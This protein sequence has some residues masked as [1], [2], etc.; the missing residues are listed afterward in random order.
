M[1]NPLILDFEMYVF[2]SDFEHCIIVVLKGIK[3]Y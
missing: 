3:G 1:K 2:Q